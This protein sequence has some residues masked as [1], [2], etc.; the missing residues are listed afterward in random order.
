MKKMP[1]TRTHALSPTERVHEYILL[2]VCIGICLVFFVK[3]MI[4]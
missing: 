4:L 3:I 2:G 1:K